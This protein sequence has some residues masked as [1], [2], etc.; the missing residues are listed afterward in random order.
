MNGKAVLITL[1]IGL[2]TFIAGWYLSTRLRLNEEDVRS[3]RNQSI[4]GKVSRVETTSSN[5]LSSSISGR[6]VLAESG[7]AGLNFISHDLVL[8][9]NEISCD[10]PDTLKIRWLNDS[11]F[12]T[13]NIL[14]INKD[15]PPRVD[16]YNVVSFDG[17]QLILRD[18][19]TGW[20][21]SKDEIFEF[22]R[23]PD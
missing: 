6:F 23:Q 7:C 3:Q 18:I 14:R 10:D 2:T 12:M 5:N 16:I 20:N 9:T 17:K 4:V 15:C 11:S 22:F 1:L 8:W 21:D 13:R 19:W